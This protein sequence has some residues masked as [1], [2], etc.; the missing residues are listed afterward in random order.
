MNNFQE[1]KLMR[2]LRALCCAV[3]I[4]ACVAPGLRADEYTKQTFL[5]FSGPV[6][7]PGVTLAAG[8]YMFKLADPQGD[9]RAIQVWDKDQTKL[10]TTLLTIP[11][12][13]MKVSDKPVVMFNERPSGEAQAIRSWFY[14]DE[15]YGFEFIYPKQQATR[16]AK[17]N[18][19]SVLAFNDEQSGPESFKSAKVGRVDEN[20]NM[21]DAN[22]AAPNVASN[23]GNQN[24]PGS[25]A[26][27]TNGSAPSTTTT[28]ATTAQANTS[29]NNAP[30]NM[31]NRRDAVGTS[32]TTASPAHDNTAADRS[33]AST[34]A[35]DNAP[36]L[37]QADRGANAGTANNNRNQLPRTAGST[38][39]IELLGVLAL[40]AA[41]SAR[42]LRTRLAESQ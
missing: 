29:D 30:Q 39:T 17:E 36:R 12:Q 40:A 14:P 34:T 20:G 11:D 28:P 2:G 41:V 37:N 32:G 9:R 38:T 13:R 5:T 22:K 23:D 21:T 4:T 25:T 35:T 15:S 31:N 27:R 24:A 19:S 3:A 6:Q 10:Y 18:H 26:D 16:I 1:G 8:T 7:L 33:S 42:S